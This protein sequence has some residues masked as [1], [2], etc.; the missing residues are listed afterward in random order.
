VAGL[1]K[2]V[3]E[4]AKASIAQKKYA[5]AVSDKIEAKLK[6]LE[7]QA[8]SQAGKGKKGLDAATLARVRQEFY[9]IA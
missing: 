5:A 1:S 2:A 6:A 8:Q 4:L 7:A 3:A 9:G